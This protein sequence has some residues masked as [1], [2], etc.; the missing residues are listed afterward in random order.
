MKHST[1]Y[2]S[3]RRFKLNLSI[4]PRPIFSPYLQAVIL[5][6]HP[7]DVPC[8]W[9]CPSG[10]LI[11]F[12]VTPMLGPQR[13]HQYQQ[14]S[15]GPGTSQYQHHIGFRE[16]KT[17]YPDQLT[18]ASS[19]TIS[20]VVDSYTGAHLGYAWIGAKDNTGGGKV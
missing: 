12:P 20:V 8:P 2:K 15:W 7:L 5:R 18:H 6:E 13:N 16:A 11:L 3:L 19:G 14:P 9:Y 10:R 1:V 17:L 4:N